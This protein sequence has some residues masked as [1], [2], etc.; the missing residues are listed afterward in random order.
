MISWQEIAITVHFL[1]G[2]EGGGDSLSSIMNSKSVSVYEFNF[3]NLINHNNLI[4]QNQIP[5]HKSVILHLIF[6][7]QLQSFTKYLRLT[8]VFM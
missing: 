3:L 7:K 1:E 4:N 5:P 8:L 2:R 6:Y